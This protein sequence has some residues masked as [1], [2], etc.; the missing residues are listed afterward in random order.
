MYASNVSAAIFWLCRVPF[1]SSA[2]PI[3][4]RVGSSYARDRY[5]RVTLLVIESARFCV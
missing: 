4:K 1:R 3:F 2:R 5:E